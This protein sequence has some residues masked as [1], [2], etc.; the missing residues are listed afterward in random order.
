MIFSNRKE[1]IDFFSENKSNT[2]NLSDTIFLDLGT[3]LMNGWQFLEGYIPLKF[4]I[5]N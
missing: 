5:K 1:C 3:P 4:D 2:I